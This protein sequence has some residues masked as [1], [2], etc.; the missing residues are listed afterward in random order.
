MKSKWAFRELKLNQEW[1]KGKDFEH[2][3]HLRTCSPLIYINNSGREASLHLTG[4][5][6]EAGSG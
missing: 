1:R 4:K 5:K 3:M 2:R 6:S